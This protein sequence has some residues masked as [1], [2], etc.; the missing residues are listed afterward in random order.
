M[1]MKSKSGLTYVA[2][3]RNG[4]PEHKM[5]HL[6][7]FSVGMFALQAVNEKTEE[8]RGKGA[9]TPTL[10]H[11]WHGLDASLRLPRVISLTSVLTGSKFVWF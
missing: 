2:E 1:V 8:E 3:L 11:R 7:C 5:G 6:A 9:N 10:T 4:L